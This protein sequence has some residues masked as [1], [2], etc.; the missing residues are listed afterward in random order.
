MDIITSNID[1]EEEIIK[2]S[3]D[4]NTNKKL[5]MF[6]K[7]YED[8]K[9]EHITD[10]NDYVVKMVNLYIEKYNQAPPPRH[11]IMNSLTYYLHMK[12]KQNLLLQL[13]NI[14]FIDFSNEIY[15]GPPMTDND[16]ILDDSDIDDEEEIIS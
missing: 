13:I 14:P 10:T 2:L 7:V 16:Y 8:L 6:K 4:I 1:D 9:D 3:E 12:G 15:T 5:P 11:V